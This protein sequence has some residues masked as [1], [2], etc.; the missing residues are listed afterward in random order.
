M[1]EQKIPIN[2]LYALVKPRMKELLRE[3]CIH[4]NLKGA[5]VCGRAVAGAIRTALGVRG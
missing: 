3:D 2:D 4:L 1:Q 5:E